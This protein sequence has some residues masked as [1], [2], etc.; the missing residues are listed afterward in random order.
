MPIRV[1]ITPGDRHPRLGKRKT[2]AARYVR[3]NRLIDAL[4]I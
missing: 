3:N 1:A 2:V 4:M